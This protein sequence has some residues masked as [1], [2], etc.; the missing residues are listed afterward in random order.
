VRIEVIAGP[1]RQPTK[2][3]R[4]DLIRRS[5]QSSATDFLAV[6]RTPALMRG[7][8]ERVPRTSHGNDL[9]LVFEADTGRPV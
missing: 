1:E 8:L 5:R 6:N 2:W 4:R 7:L 3:E 9:A